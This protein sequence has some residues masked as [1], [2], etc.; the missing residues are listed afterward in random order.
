M[1]G[2]KPYGIVWKIGHGDINGDNSMLHV[3]STLCDKVKEV[4]WSNRAIVLRIDIM[5]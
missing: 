3:N 4:T 2:I 5:F 1:R